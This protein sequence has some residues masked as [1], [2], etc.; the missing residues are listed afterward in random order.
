M[1]RHAPAFLHLCH[2]SPILPWSLEVAGEDQ[3]LVLAGEGEVR[4]SSY[5]R[6]GD[7]PKPEAVDASEKC[8]SEVAFGMGLKAQTALPV[9]MKP[10]GHLCISSKCRQ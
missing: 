4:G 7:R 8:E 9:T 5:A 1:T 10:V 6:N 3:L 2:V